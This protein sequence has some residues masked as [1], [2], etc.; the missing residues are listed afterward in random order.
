MLIRNA[1]LIGSVLF[2]DLSKSLIWVT[3]P[4]LQPSIAASASEAGMGNGDRK[5]ESDSESEVNA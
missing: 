3:N 1:P 5:I 2:A 4:M